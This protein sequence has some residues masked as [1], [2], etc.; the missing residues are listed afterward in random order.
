MCSS[1]LMAKEILIP[2]TDVVAFD[3]DSPLEDVQKVIGEHQYSRYPVYEGDLDTVLGIVT[4]KDLMRYL[5]NRDAEPFS[6]RRLALQRKTMYVPGSKKI[7]ELLKQFQREHVQM[8]IVVDEF[9]G[10]AGIV[11]VEDVLEEIVGEIYDEHEKAEAPVK[12]IAPGL[13][14]VQARVAI[15]EIED[16]FG[17]E[18]PEQDVYE[19]V[20]GLVIT[21]AG[22]VPHKDEAVEF[23]G[24]T[25][26]ILDRTRTRV[27]LLEVR[28]TRPAEDETGEAEED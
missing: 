12:E 5:A 24:L 18:W 1:D 22:R 26:R 4:V 27:N 28:R 9:G 11:T 7:G 14:Q 6:L 25:F 16:L 20:G 8:A 21:Q 17:I 10:T 2:R 13:Y 23:A 15:E 19:T 3:V